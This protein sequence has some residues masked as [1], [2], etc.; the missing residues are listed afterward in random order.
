MGATTRPVL[1]IDELIDLDTVEH[2]DQGS[3]PDGGSTVPGETTSCPQ[4]GLSE[5]CELHSSQQRWNLR[6]LAPRSNQQFATS[7]I[8]STREHQTIRHIPGPALQLTGHVFSLDEEISRSIDE[9]YAQ[10][11]RFLFN[12]L[13]SIQSVVAFKRALSDLRGRKCADDLV[14]KGARS[15]AEHLRIVKKLRE[16]AAADSLLTMCHTVRLF[17]G[18]TDDLLLHPG[19]FVV[20]TQTSFGRLRRTATGNPLSLSKAAITDRKIALLYP[21]LVPGS[22]EYKAERRYI[23]RLRQSAA[24]LELFS[25][26]FGFGIVAFL[27]YADPI[28]NGYHLNKWA[29]TF[30]N[31]C[32]LDLT[33]SILG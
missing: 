13:G 14:L 18:D 11:L 3:R 33:N 25:K 26:M 31:F 29:S 1:G 2:S 8:Q 19:S 22:E 4:S 16:N 17:Q 28:G 15:D 32:G 9:P 10:Q 30:K 21:S 23:T 6:P 27:P 20:Q 12:Y 7:P 5:S 24:K